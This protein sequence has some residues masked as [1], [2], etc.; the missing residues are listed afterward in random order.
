MKK[1]YIIRNIILSFGALIILIWAFFQN[2]LFGK[3]IITPFLVCS[4]AML[5]ENIF[6]LLNRIKISNVFKSIFRISFFVYIF[7][8]LSYMV[9][10]AIT[11]RSYSILI[12]V[13]IFLLFAIY[14]IKKS[15]FNNK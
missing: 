12:I 3:I 13:I 9:Y 15:F 8:F 7:G 4:F 10:Y 6:L 2:T 14:F 5:F 1:L 11:N